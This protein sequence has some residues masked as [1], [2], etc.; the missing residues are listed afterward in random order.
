MSCR[1]ISIVNQKGG[2]GK[3][4]TA[5]N[6]ATALAAVGNRVLLIDNDPQGN[7]TSGFGVSKQNIKTLYDTMLGETDVS[8]V[9]L[10]TC[11]PKLFI[12]PSDITLA[13][14]EIELATQSN[15]RT[16]LKRKLETIKAA[17]DY[18]LIDC[19][20]TLG[21][22]T[23]NSLVASSSVLIPL[24]CEFFALEG[25]KHL[26]ETIKL[27]KENLNA[28]LR[29]DGIVLTMYDR[30]NNLTLLIEKDV[31]ACLRGA[32]YETVI[33]RN[34]TLSEA[35]SHGKPILIYNKDCA[36]SVAYIKLTKEFLKREKI[37]QEASV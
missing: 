23:L 27:V 6:L 32:V 33:P 11:I 37:N 4:T 17:Y 10:E 30:R 1:T 24:Q 21:L 8:E 20:P 36:G 29:I 18:I 19:P 2:V 14:A 22:L 34:V 5:G 35:A 16:I 25:L 7:T 3:T 12:L 26:M 31:R 15:F 13:A 9:I 28:D